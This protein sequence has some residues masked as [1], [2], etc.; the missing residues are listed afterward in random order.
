MDDLSFKIDKLSTLGNDKVLF[1]DLVIDSE[2]MDRYLEI[3]GYV[4]DSLDSGVDKGIIGR[5][6]TYSKM[7][8]EYL[9]TKDVENLLCISLFEKNKRRDSRSVSIELLNMISESFENI[10]RNPSSDDIDMTLYMLGTIIS[11][12]LGFLK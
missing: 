12:T 1:R 9:K 10:F 5:L 4:L 3:K 2:M 7:Y 8:K 11:D 6:S